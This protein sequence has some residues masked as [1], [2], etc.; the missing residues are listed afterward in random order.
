MFHLIIVNCIILPFHGTSSTF[1]CT[2]LSIIFV[3]CHLVRMHD[4]CVYAC[5]YMYFHILMN[6]WHCMNCLFICTVYIMHCTVVHYPIV[7]SFVLHSTLIKL[8]ASYLNTGWVAHGVMVGLTSGRYRDAVDSNGSVSTRCT[9]DHYA[10]R[11][12]IPMTTIYLRDTRLN[13]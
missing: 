3:R 4:I 10:S 7:I 11:V 2:F 12:F 1:L 6:A 8:F 5:R 9:F 13:V